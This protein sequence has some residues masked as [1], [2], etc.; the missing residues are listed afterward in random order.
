VL[1]IAGALL[2]ATAPSARILVPFFA[3]AAADAKLESRVLR[4]I[5]AIAVVLQLFLVAYFFDRT[6]VFSILAAKQSDEQFLTAARPSYAQIGW[7]DANLPA[8]SRTLVIGLNETYWFAHRVRGGGNFDG[9]RVDAYL[10]A[11]TPEAL[12]ARIEHD[13]ITHVAVFNEPKMTAVAQKQEERQTHLS[14]AARRAVAQMLDRYAA[15]VTS[16]G[17]VTLFTLR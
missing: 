12:R 1:L 9:P 8:T 7:V 13:G 14:P 4:G 6:N 16:R 17:D 3:T 15:S 2:W 10:D 5:I 11:P